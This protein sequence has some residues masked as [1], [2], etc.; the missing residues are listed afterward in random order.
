[1]NSLF[2]LLR[3]RANQTPERVGYYFSANGD[4]AGV[5]M[6]YGELDRAAR[7]IAAGLRDARD[8]YG[9]VLLL[10]PPG[11]G[12]I[13]AFFGCI[14]AGLPAA[15]LAPPRQNEFLGPLLRVAMNARPVAAITTRALRPFL[16]QAFQSLDS[17]VV[18]LAA[19]DLLEHDADDDPLEQPT[20]TAFIQYTSGTTGAS[21]G[22]CVTHANILNNLNIIASRFGHS[23]DSRGVIWLPPYHDMGLIGGILQ[24]L[25]AHFPVT[26]FPPLAFAQRPVRWL[27]MISR[28]RATTSGGPNFAYDSCVERALRHADDTIDLSSWRVAFNGAEPLH[29][30]T[31]ERFAQAFRPFG[32]RRIAFYPCYGLAEA[33]LFVSGGHLKDTEWQS[34]SCGAP[35][36]HHTVQIR[37][38]DSQTALPEGSIG[39]ICVSG[40]SVT[41][42]YWDGASRS[43]KRREGELRTGDL[44]FLRGGELHITGRIKD[45]IIIRGRNLAPADLERAIADEINL[46]VLDSC[47]AFSVVLDTREQLIVLIELSG[48]TRRTLDLSAAVER[49]RA[50]I[51]SSFGIE[52]FDLLFV[53]SGA[54]SRTTSGKIKRVECRERYLTAQFERLPLDVGKIV[55]VEC[56]T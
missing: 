39:E 5:P 22:V 16:H 20:E 50:R 38:A 28:I 52:P 51:T 26:L 47:V 40:P 27:K 41:P 53:E 25:F 31:L 34:V 3:L 6:S 42:G 36:A 56:I 35:D 8:A 1:M 15:P 10:L 33:T 7:S 21:R 29:V 48:R 12:F 17:P 45:L 32:F 13:Q 46:S 54:L 37:E 18:I 30:A 23:T 11:L 2:Q 49:V 55:D 19:E 43:V 14:Y 44:G 24:P 4:D 9:P